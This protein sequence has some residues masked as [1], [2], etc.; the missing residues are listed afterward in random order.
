MIRTLLFAVLVAL[1]SGCDSDSPGDADT[2]AVIDGDADADSDGD[3]DTDSDADSDGDG[4]TDADLDHEEE[5][6][7]ERD[8]SR[9][10]TGEELCGDCHG[11]VDT[12]GPP[13]DTN[14]LTD[15]AMVTVGAHAAHF[16]GGGFTRSIPCTECHVQPATV[17]DLGHCDS[18]MPAEV[19]FGPVASS[20][21][22][23]PY[24][25]RADVNCSLVYCHGA[26]L[27][28]GNL[29]SPSWTQGGPMECGGC[30]NVTTYHGE[31]NCYECHR[32]VSAAK[33]IIEPALHINGRVD[34]L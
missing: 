19:R 5:A 24:W 29:E 23:Y 33:E 18:P 32:S 16:D 21:G 7:V 25:N 22:M 14:G 30:H 17:L 11:G 15:T 34:M 4:D 28:G 27:E 26:T 6:D 9:C 2:D 3:G 20:D 31:P 10:G 13:P 8:L 1:A 12:G